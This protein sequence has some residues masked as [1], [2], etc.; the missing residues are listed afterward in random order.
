MFNSNSTSSMQPKKDP[1]L[2]D[3]PVENPPTDSISS[4]KYSPVEDILTACSWDGS[5]YIYAPSNPSSHESMTLKTSIPNPNGSP[6]LCSCFSGD[7]RYL[8]TGSA[9][10]C[11]RYIDMLNG[12]ISELGKHSLA[13]S[14]MTFTNTMTLITG[15]WDK[16]V[17]V[18]NMSNPQ[19]L[20]KEIVLDEKVFSMDSK[21]NTIVILLSSSFVAY[22][23]YT[24][25]KIL[26]PSVFNKPR[27]SV[28]ISSYGGS[29]T[30]TSNKY[31]IKSQWQLRCVA[32]SN[33]GQDVLVGTSGS[34]A[35]IVAIRPGNGIS[36]N[37][38]A[39]R[40]KQNLGNRDAYPVNSVRF[41][42]SFPTTILTAGADGV[43][44][45]WNKQV[46][47][48]LGIGGPGVDS[49]DR[50]ITDASF[51]R[52]GRYLAI[53]GGY[54]WSQGYKSQIS[55]PVEIRIIMIPEDLHS[56]TGL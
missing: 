10:G 32:C 34:K 4:L 30:H 47:C 12:S 35:E 42:P 2:T 18:W 22:D 5:V 53:A 33:D 17:K 23:T 26:P 7:G 43:A 27:A 28:S 11:V 16:T 29:S 50:C 14:C 24:L 8:F 51:N 54:D 15:S 1:V 40:C 38:Y 13:V 56:R 48:R 37:Y 49:S 31:Q 39:F 46:K 52:T 25:E 3:F 44:I 41:H 36:N 19:P 20:Q 45:L 55:M 21:M 9:D 6:I